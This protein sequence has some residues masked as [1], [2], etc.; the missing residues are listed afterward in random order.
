MWMSREEACIVALSIAIQGRLP[1]ALQVNT[2]KGVACC[3]QVDCARQ[4][5]IVVLGKDDCWR[6][7]TALLQD[8]SWCDG[9][10]EARYVSARHEG[11]NNGS[12]FS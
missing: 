2:A 11:A 10:V 4:E 7:E 3:T 5:A 1:C 8:R 6:H 9:R 12:Q